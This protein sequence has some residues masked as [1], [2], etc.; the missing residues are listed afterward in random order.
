MSG[1]QGT[2][3]PAIMASSVLIAVHI[4]NVDIRS[5][6]DVRG[7]T[8]SV[9]RC[10]KLLRSILCSDTCSFQGRRR[11]SSNLFIKSGSGGLA[12]STPKNLAQ[13][14]MLPTHPAE[15]P[16]S[17]ALD[18]Y[19]TMLPTARTMIRNKWDYCRLLGKDRRKTR[20]TCDTNSPNEPTWRGFVRR[21]REAS[22]HAD[23]GR[24]RSGRFLHLSR[25]YRCMDT[26][27]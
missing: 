23:P 10:D 14:P 22:P 4:S 1:K 11:L 3:L 24:R 6:C 26:R 21:P 8:A 9:W 18:N 19:A 16:R 12:S 27:C 13:S 15:S 2:M 25:R 17:L 20:S 7:L 5:I